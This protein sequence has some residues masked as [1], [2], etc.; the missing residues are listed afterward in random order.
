MQSALS[1][2]QQASGIAVRCC[3][4]ADNALD[5]MPNIIRFQYRLEKW[6]LYGVTMT[7][8][9]P[10]GA[11]ASPGE[12]CRHADIVRQSLGKP[13]LLV[14]DS[15]PAY[16]RT[17]LTVKQQPF[18]AAGTQVFMPNML[19]MANARRP[20]VK[21][22][23]TY[24][25]APAQLI[26][27]SHLLHRAPDR[28]TGRELAR[29]FGGS[30]MTWS[31]ALSELVALTVGEETR[32]HKFRHFRFVL[33]PRELWEKLQPHLRTPVMKSLHVRSMPEFMGVR[34]G[35]SALSMLTDIAAPEVPELAVAAPAYR[36]QKGT[37]ERIPWPEP[38]SVLMQVWRYDPGPLAQ[39]GHVDRFSLYLSMRD[40]R[41]ERVE[42]AR[43][44]L[45]EAVRW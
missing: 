32:V 31:R 34:A 26:V 18:V 28:M 1:Y 27:L 7:A 19:L 39:E 25:S 6:E 43:A 21:I 42:K 23:P 37:I 15:L 13:S 11:N 8:M 30:T 9:K 16:V 33:P 2:L 24:L 5:A 38:G 29:Q 22:A 4:V 40:D 45:M 44:Q 36:A 12:L 3:P 10:V 35:Y 20:A 17:R 41:D 14:F